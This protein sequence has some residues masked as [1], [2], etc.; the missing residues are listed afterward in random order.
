MYHLQ[1]HLNDLLENCVQNKLSLLLI[2]QIGLVHGPTQA[3][4]VLTTLFF[5][6]SFSS[7]TFD[8]WWYLYSSFASN[9]SELDTYVIVRIQN[10][11]SRYLLS[12]IESQLQLSFKEDVFFSNMLLW[13]DHAK[14][15]YAHFSLHL[16]ALATSTFRNCAPGL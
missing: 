2:E 8:A 12:N 13:V 15:E 10:S 1:S 6:Q 7:D 4:H 9:I 16:Y 11:F 5:S 3:S 14:Q